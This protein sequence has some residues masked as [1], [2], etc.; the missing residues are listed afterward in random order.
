V[1]YSAKEYR[2]CTKYTVAQD[3]V[4]ASLAAAWAGGM[5]GIIGIKAT[6]VDALLG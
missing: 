4:E 2:G 1:A 5:M 6:K 3:A